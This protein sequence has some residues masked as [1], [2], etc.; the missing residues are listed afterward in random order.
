M[1]YHMPYFDNLPYLEKICGARN[2]P[3]WIMTHK[4]IAQ[5]L[6]VVNMIFFV[7]WGLYYKNKP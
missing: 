6:E 5:G 7:L 2:P 1:M 4:K 3:L